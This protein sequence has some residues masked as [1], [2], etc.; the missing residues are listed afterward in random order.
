MNNVLLLL[1]FGG[2]VGLLL[3]VFY[4][5]DRVNALHNQNI[6]AGLKRP[7]LDNSFFGLQGKSL[8]DAVSGVPTPGVDEQMLESI[9]NRYEM[10]LQKHIELLF[11]DGTLDGREG[12][13]MPISS[14]R[15]V[16]TL[17]GE[18]SSWIP[19]EFASGIYRAGH[20]RATLPPTEHGIIATSLDQIG[21]MLF[22]AC[23]FPPVQLSKLLM[24]NWDKDALQAAQQPPPTGEAQPSLPAPTPDAAALPAPDADAAA[25]AIAAAPVATDPAAA[26]APDATAAPAAEAAPAALPGPEAASPV[27][28]DQTQQAQPAPVPAAAPP[29]NT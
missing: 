19:H 28:P 9:K 21:S 27:L 25:A 18:I 15:K 13:S 5:L 24:P 26:P 12:F 29:A 6:Q 23:G 10:V 2:L 14:D 1:I 11:E 8:W 16:P 20:S 7:P 17:R 4:L 22:P 3:V